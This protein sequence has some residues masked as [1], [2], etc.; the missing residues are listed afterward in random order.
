MEDNATI[1]TT[2]E[3]VNNQIE[4]ATTEPKRRSRTRTGIYMLLD[5]PY[6]THAEFKAIC[7]QMNLPISI[8]GRLVIQDFVRRYR[9]NPETATLTVSTTAK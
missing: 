4:D 2:N 5:V 7:R 1:E 6:S 9:E 3:L 8:A